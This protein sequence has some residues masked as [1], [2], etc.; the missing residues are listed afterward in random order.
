MATNATIFMAMSLDGRLAG[1]GDDLSFLDTVQT[2]GEDYGFT[3]FFAGVDALVMGRRTYEVVRTFGNWPYGDKPVIVLSET[4]AGQPG[5]L[6][7]VRFAA[8]DVGELARLLEAEGLSRLYV[9]GGSV[10][11]GF[12]AAGLCDA[13]IVSIVPII[14]GAGP[15]LF[16][17]HE[18]APLPPSQWRLAWSERY[19]SGLMQLCY[20]RYLQAP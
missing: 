1:P 18:G 15:R 4:L 16:D 12:I 11:R 14:L 17:D 20:E 6:P 7:T 2:D 3:S 9:D 8:G 10:A 5:P 13:L 19:E